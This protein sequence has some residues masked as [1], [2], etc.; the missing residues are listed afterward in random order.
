MFQAEEAAQRHR[1]ERETG[2]LLKPQVYFSSLEHRPKWAA[3]RNEAAEESDHGQ[4]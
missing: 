3:P 2:L 4:N 1:N